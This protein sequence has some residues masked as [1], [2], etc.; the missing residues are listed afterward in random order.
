MLF[1]FLAKQNFRIGSPTYLQR[2][3]VDDDSKTNHHWKKWNK[4]SDSLLYNE[5]DISMESLRQELS[6][7]ISNSQESYFEYSSED[8]NYMKQKNS[9]KNHWEEGMKKPLITSLS[10]LEDDVE[11]DND[12]VSSY[13][14]F[15]LNDNTDEDED[16][17]YDDINSEDDDN[18]VFDELDNF[19][20]DGQKCHSN[21]NEQ[22]KILSKTLNEY[23][24]K[25]LIYDVLKIELLY[26]FKQIEQRC[27]K[28]YYRH[29][30]AISDQ[31]SDH[32]Q[33][34]KLFEEMYLEE[35]EQVMQCVNNVR[36]QVQ[37]LNEHIKSSEIM[38]DCVPQKNIVLDFDLNDI[39]LK[40]PL[41]NVLMDKIDPFLL[42]KFKMSDIDEND[43]LK[44]LLQNNK[45]LSN[46]NSEILVSKKPEVKFGELLP[47]RYNDL[48]IPQNDEKYFHF[49]RQIALQTLPH[50]LNDFSSNSDLNL[51]PHPSLI[52]QAI[53]MSN[54]SDGINLERLE[55]VGDSFL[56]FALFNYSN[57][58]I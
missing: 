28:R 34:R 43:Q 58:L 26:D 46:D 55:T 5:F 39:K 38:I 42:E 53:T 16:D 11:S 25:S 15:E 6:C 51:G 24:L 32:L 21:N 54:S 57:I 37:L 33:K 13:S 29:R 49:Q 18:D 45:N 17:D 14:D 56:K 10:D 20:N 19:E 35:K 47:N 27:L 30:F 36:Q 40:E 4:N 23:Q 12:N 8:V 7:F 9:N 44:Q 22:I 50:W 3:F 52:L 2:Q 48:Y 31:E 41:I 1:L